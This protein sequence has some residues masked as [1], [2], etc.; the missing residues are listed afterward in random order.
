MRFYL[1]L[2][3]SVHL[4]S[5]KRE[6]IPPLGAIQSFLD[7]SDTATLY[8]LAT[9]NF[10]KKSLKKCKKKII[11]TLL[12]KAKFLKDKRSNAKKHEVFYVSKKN[13]C[14]C[15]NTVHM[16]AEDIIGFSFDLNWLEEQ[17]W[18]ANLLEVSFEKVAKKCKKFSRQSLDRIEAGQ[19]VVTIMLTAK[20]NKCFLLPL[21]KLKKK[22]SSSNLLLFE[23]FS[24]YIEQKTVEYRL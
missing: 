23:I 9:Q 2:N 12:N 24:I 7:C 13:S 1:L 10:N 3:S 21:I 6:G 5:S 15:Q 8:C 17:I 14:M 22:T 20:L 18:T 19:S 16:H 11:S 4:F